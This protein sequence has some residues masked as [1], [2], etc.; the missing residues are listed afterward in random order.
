MALTQIYDLF[1]NTSGVIISATVHLLCFYNGCYS[2]SL[3]QGDSNSNL[4]Q[5]DFSIKT[6]LPLVKEHQFFQYK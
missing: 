1:L 5:L 2:K 6:Y 3:I 4:A